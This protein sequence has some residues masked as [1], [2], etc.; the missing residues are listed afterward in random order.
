[1]RW[2]G[3]PDEDR[4][5]IGTVDCD[6]CGGQMQ[7]DEIYTDKHG[8]V[9]C[10]ICYKRGWPKNKSKTNKTKNKKL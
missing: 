9:L 10:Q 6:L 3:M 1:M 7:E 2:D 4:E 5:D 8:N